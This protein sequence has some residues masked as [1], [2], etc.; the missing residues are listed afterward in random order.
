M[1]NTAMEGLHIWPKNYR[2]IPEPY[3]VWWLDSG[4]FIGMK[5]GE[6]CTQ[7]HW[8]RFIVRRWVLKMAEEDKRTEDASAEK[9]EEE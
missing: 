3:S 5:N 8:N 4:H 2:P 9:K 7:I 6:E 1:H